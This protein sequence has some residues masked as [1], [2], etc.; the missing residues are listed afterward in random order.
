[1]HVIFNPLSARFTRRGKGA[2][3]RKRFS[4]CHHP[5]FFTPDTI[6]RK[7]E[8]GRGEEREKAISRNKNT[9]TNK[10]QPHYVAIGK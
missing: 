10:T 6:T 4:F 7:E 8:R 1:M 3:A 5:L 2:K 9:P